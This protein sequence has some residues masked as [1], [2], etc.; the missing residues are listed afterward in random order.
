MN[1]KYRSN[2]ATIV[3]QLAGV[4]FFFASLAIVYLFVGELNSVSSIVIALVSLLF[5]MG[6]ESYQARNKA[7]EATKTQAVAIE[8]LYDRINRTHRFERFDSSDHV[9][10]HSIPYLREAKVVRN[11][12]VQLGGHADPKTESY[13]SIVK[14]YEEFLSKPSAEWYDIVSLRELYDPRF[15]EIFK[16][17]SS[18]AP[19]QPIPG[20][21]WIAV[22]RHNVPLINFILISDRNGDMNRV[23]FGWV[24]DDTNRSSP[25]CH[26]TDPAIV[27]MFVRYF[28]MLWRNKQMRAGPIFVD[29]TKEGDDRLDGSKV[30]DRKGIWITVALHQPEKHLPESSH[31]ARATIDSI[32][33][34]GID[35]TAIETKLTGCIYYLEP[36]RRVTMQAENVVTSLSAIHFRYNNSYSHA[37]SAEDRKGFAT[38]NFEEIDGYEYITGFLVEPTSAGWLKLLGVRLRDESASHIGK[39]SPSFAAK[40]ELDDPRVQDALSRIRERLGESAQLMGTIGQK[41]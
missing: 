37:F 11:T 3:P 36:K 23:Y 19:T 21:H 32:G 16:N 2:I 1:S 10:L 38:Y 25:V 5:T 26:T 41:K 17:N 20:K 34:L 13:M 7:E 35:F 14:A 24:V 4:I 27:G 8:A 29:Y 40:I 18:R 9:A 28:E 22:L 33:I 39:D 12:F 15:R 31:Q 30:F 6:A